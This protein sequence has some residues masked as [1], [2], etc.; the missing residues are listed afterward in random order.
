MEFIM[1][2]SYI[3]VTIAMVA[4][5]VLTA[6]AD[7]RDPNRLILPLDHGPRAQTTPWENQQRRLR[8]AQ[9]AAPKAEV[10]SP[11]NSDPNK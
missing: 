9:E 10:R 4:S 2:T 3:K 7:L 11:S 5:I 8:A 1:K 6:C